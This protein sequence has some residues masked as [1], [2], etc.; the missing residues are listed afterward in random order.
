ML[1]VERWLVVQRPRKYTQSQKSRV[2]QAFASHSASV[3][4]GKTD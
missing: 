3:I 4:Q 2:H 1:Q